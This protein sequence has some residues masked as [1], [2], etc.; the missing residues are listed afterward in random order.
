MLTV[1]AILAI[2][3]VAIFLAKKKKKV[4]EPKFEVPE[5]IEI[6]SL[7]QATV[8]DTVAEIIPAQERPESKKMPIAEPQA[9]EQ[10]S[11][12]TQPKK[13]KYNKK[14]APKKMDEKKIVE[15]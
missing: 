15:K 9:K 11:V 2:L 13:R 6:I 7:E 3:A 5:K 14:K 8:A 1:I 10:V 12:E 4:I